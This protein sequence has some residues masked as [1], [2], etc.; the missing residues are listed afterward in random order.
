MIVIVFIIIASLTIVIYDNIFTV[1]ATVTLLSVL[2]VDC[3]NMTKYKILLIEKMQARPQQP[4][5]FSKNVCNSA[6]GK[7]IV[8]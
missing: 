6:T 8:D 5:A 4:S 7:L 3:T 2:Y 1:Q